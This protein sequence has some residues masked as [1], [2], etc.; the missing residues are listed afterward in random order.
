MSK[1]E[2]WHFDAGQQLEPCVRTFV[3]TS[4]DSDKS[5]PFNATHYVVLNVH[6]RM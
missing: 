1:P 2:I 3:N 5:W 4:G 6:A